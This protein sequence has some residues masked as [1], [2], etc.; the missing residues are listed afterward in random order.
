M[1][2]PVPPAGKNHRGRSI[3]F[4]VNAY[5]GEQDVVELARQAA[6]GE[7]PRRDYVELAR[8][9]DAKVIDSHYLRREG[10]LLAKVLAQ[11]N[12]P[13]AQVCQAFLRCRRCQKIFAWSDRVG[14]PLALL[15]KVVFSRRVL[16]LYSAWLSRPKKAMLLQR[17]KVH[18]HL[19]AI[20]NYSSVQMNYAVSE[21]GVPRKKLHLAL[22]PVDDRFWRPGVASDERVICS[23]GWEARDYR[24]LVEAVKG[25]EVDVEV[26][27]GISGFSSTRR[28]DGAGGRR[29]QAEDDVQAFLQPL[30]GSYSYGLQKEWFRHR[31]QQAVSDNVSVRWQL[32]PQELR[33]LYR[34][35]RFVVVPLLDV[36]SDCG[37]TTLT[38]AMAM[39]KAVVVTRTRGQVDIVGDGEHGVYVP[40]GDADALRSVI[41]H[42]LDHPEEAERM[43]KAGRALIEAH[44]TMDSHLAHLADIIATST[45]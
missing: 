1:S 6:A 37:V 22:Q 12:L 10:L 40:P 35:S 26:A 15:L 18:S 19:R 3:A 34:R 14:L 33:E 2:I 31:S 45:E 44:H 16:I 13:L 25:L 38:E 28:D 4:L 5:P 7:S 43:G 17:F 29:S 32:S 20:I 39:G 41:E 11:V 27:I 23:V 36:D 8:M 30:K 21:L 24:T 42:L 9:L